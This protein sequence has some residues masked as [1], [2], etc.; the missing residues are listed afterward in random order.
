MADKRV[1]RL[2][3]PQDPTRPFVRVPNRAKG[4]QWASCNSTGRMGK[5]RGRGGGGGGSPQSVREVHLVFRDYVPL[6]AQAQIRD[7]IAR[8]Q[9]SANVM[10]AGGGGLTAASILAIAAGFFPGVVGVGAGLVFLFGGMITFTF[11]EF[12]EFAAYETVV[13]V[14]FTTPCGAGDNEGV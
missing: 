3:N 6:S 7:N 2:K 1:V 13:Y 12:A 4:V 14:R 11:A 5:G 10:M 8:L 9:Q